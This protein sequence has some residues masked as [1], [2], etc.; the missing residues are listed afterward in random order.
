[1]SED[2]KGA[3]MIKIENLEKY[4][5]KGRENEIHAVNR[6]NLEFDK[7][8]LVCIVGESGCGKTTLLNIIG[9]LDSFQSGKISI[10]DV[11]IR[12]YSAKKAEKL[13]VSNFSYI[14]QNYYL[15]QDYTVDYNI[16]I[17]L[18]MFDISE[19]EKDSRVDYVL[20]AL[21]IEKYRKRNVSQL[22]SGQRQ[23]VAI[24]R[25]LVKSPSV[26]FADEP[27][28]NLDEAN[29][30]KTMDILKKISKEH[31]VILVTHEKNIVDFYAD[32]V[33]YVKDGTVERDVTNSESRF[34]KRTDDSNLYL[35]EYEPTILNN[36]NVSVNLY[37]D[38]SENKFT[39]NMICTDGK[40]YIQS[41]DEKEI[42]FLTADSRTKMIDSTKPEYEPTK[43]FDFNLPK[44]KISKT[45][46][47]SFKEIR[48]MTAANLQVLGKKQIFMMVTFILTAA[49]LVI[50]VANYITL[51]TVDKT[52]IITDDSHYITVK[53]E[54]NN[55]VT[56]DTYNQNFNNFYEQLLSSGYAEDVYMELRDG[57]STTGSILHSKTELDFRHPGFGQINMIKHSVTNI[58][59]VAMEH[60]HKSDL[61]LGRMPQAPN[62]IVIDKW[63]ID[64][65]WQTENIIFQFMPTYEDF[66]GNQVEAKGKSDYLTIVG[67][68]DSNEPSIYIDKYM[69][70]N[71]ASWSD[72]I[73]S[74]EQLQAIYPGKYND[75]SLKGFEALVPESV[76]KAMNISGNL[77]KTTAYGITYTVVGFFPDELHISYV[78]TEN[79]YDAIVDA[80]NK[81]SKNFRIYTDDKEGLFTYFDTVKGD[82]KEKGI[83]I[84]VNDMSY[85][86]L[87]AYED[88]QATILI[89]WTAIS[90]VILSMAMFML[91]FSMKSNAIKRLQELTVFRVIGIVKSSILATYAL[92]IIILT[93]YT[94]LPTVVVTSI[95]IML[96]GK[97]KSLGINF[98]YPWYTMF[99][100]LLVL[101]AVNVII[102]LLPVYRIIKQPPAKIAEKL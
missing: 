61:I 18:S 34:Y 91:Y 93:N 75:L 30:L 87:K 37:H 43:E 68:C 48:K 45:P 1:M 76:Y 54:A 38:G 17:A 52:S 69:R 15:L 36:K 88:K 44:L 99:F 46:R 26:I 81:I 33:I 100:I 16:R 10:D 11:T 20:E 47:L 3:N 80:F 53:A 22:S 63:L 73:A 28:G 94:V 58:S 6:T 9:G 83:N 72:S 71:I 42:V 5:N 39:L 77:T 29:T 64:Q 27:T 66:L 97:I 14:F 102:G 95:V 2:E 57:Y 79:A 55:S 23:R 13:R 31:L 96:L 70:V 35:K 12:K 67:I 41:P 40:L 85:N 56:P 32:R 19:V 101:Y 90:A 98:N 25:A 62:E 59:F 8:G 86:Q 74:V 51:K 21:E 7:A 50:T 82:L 84:T 65:F 4:F 92:E 78:V 89:E 49:L 24:A 60:F